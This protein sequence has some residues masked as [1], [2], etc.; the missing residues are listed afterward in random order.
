M[1]FQSLS[2][3]ILLIILTHLLDFSGAFE[4]GILPFS[5][6][7]KLARRVAHENVKRIKSDYQPIPIKFLL[8]YPNLEEY[9]YYLT[10]S[11]LNTFLKFAMIITKK[12]MDF[13]WRVY[14]NEVRIMKFSLSFERDDITAL[15]MATGHNNLAEEFLAFEPYKKKGDFY[16]S[17]KILI[18]DANDLLFDYWYFMMLRIAKFSKIAFNLN[19]FL[20]FVRDS[21]CFPEKVMYYLGKHGKVNLHP[22]YWTILDSIKRTFFAGSANVPPKTYYRLMVQYIKGIIAKGEIG[23][24]KKGIIEEGFV[25]YDKDNKPISYL[26]EKYL[27]SFMETASR[28]GHS[29][30]VKMLYDALVCISQPSLCRSR[31]SSFSHSYLNKIIISCAFKNMYKND[32]CMDL[33]RNYAEKCIDCKMCRECGVIV[34]LKC[35]DKFDESFSDVDDFFDK[36]F[37]ESIKGPLK[38]VSMCYC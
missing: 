7:C 8:N 36:S 10:T 3:E 37:N 19:I 11:S 26:K 22:G 13:P 29:D 33:I 6:I 38:Y 32:Q 31:D 2:R 30:L 12:K 23:I 5:G 34:C 9:P 16:S 18:K 14:Y 28:Y 27:I 4:K 21:S 20:N 35:S 15:A 17:C 24:A 25:K 1:S